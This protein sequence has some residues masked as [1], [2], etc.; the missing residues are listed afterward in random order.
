MES[1]NTLNTGTAGN[2]TSPNITIIMSSAQKNNIAAIG[3]PNVAINLIILEDENSK[4]E[5]VSIKIGDND[6]TAYKYRSSD[7]YYLL[8]GTNTNT[9]TTGYYLYD[10]LEDTVQRYNSSIIDSVMLER[11]R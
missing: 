5:K 1:A 8:Y 3:N 10:S 4:Y 2:H 6:V 7:D 11:N 9:G